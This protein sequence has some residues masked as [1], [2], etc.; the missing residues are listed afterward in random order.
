MVEDISTEEEGVLVENK[1]Q[2]L[3]QEINKQQTIISQASQALNLC[4][5][6]VEFSNSGEQVESERL[7]LLA[8]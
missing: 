7:L 2:E 1:I 6:T 4:L 8:S 5:S 3:L